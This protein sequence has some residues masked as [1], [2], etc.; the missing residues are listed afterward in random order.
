MIRP[1]ITLDTR[2]WMLAAQDLKE[3]SSRSCADFINGQALKVAVEAIKQTKR[4]N[5]AR[6]AQVLGEI[7]REVSFG[8]VSRGKNKGKTRTKRGNRIVAE[9]SLA[10]RILGARFEQTG[11]WGVKGDTMVERARNLIASSVR[12]A[13]FIAS[14]WIP[15]FRVL[16]SIVYDKPSGTTSS[17]GAKQYGKAKGSAKPARFSFAQKI[18]CIIQNTALL[19]IGKPPSKGGDPMPVA[20]AGLQAA[21]DTAAR[22][23][24]ETLA[25][26]LK[27]DLK[28]FGAQ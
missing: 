18:E 27:R 15:A 12:S 1:H 17:Q 9:G 21:L 10:E 23:M 8:T 4:S 2:G 26:R 25:K 22:D 13:A 16:R 20:K 3:T 11:Q 6:I 28:R 5:A 7:G 14:G 19:T 24:I